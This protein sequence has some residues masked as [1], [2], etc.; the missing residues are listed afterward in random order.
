MQT[1]LLHCIGPNGDYSMRV[2][3]SNLN[4][5]CADDFTLTPTK[6]ST[7]TKLHSEDDEVLVMMTLSDDDMMM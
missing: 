2:A 7:V 6:D 4:C 3:E 5:S 1:R